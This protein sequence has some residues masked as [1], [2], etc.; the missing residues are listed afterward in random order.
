MKLF[1]NLVIT[2]GVYIWMGLACLSFLSLSGFVLLT[3]Q[4]PLLG[5]ELNIYA[6]VPILAWVLFGLAFLAALVLILKAVFLEREDWW[7]WGTLGVLLL[8]LIMFSLVML[9]VIRSYFFYGRGDGLT[10]LAFLQ[11]TLV[12]GSVAQDDLYPA[13]GFI[14]ASLAN[15]TMI[16]PRLLELNSPGIGPLLGLPF[17]YLLARVALG[18]SRQALLGMLI[19]NAATFGVTSSRFAPQDL[20]NLLSVLFIFLYLRFRWQPDPAGRTLLVLLAVVLTIVHPFS[21]TI[22]ILALVAMEIAGGILNYHHQPYGI[23]SSIQPKISLGLVFILTVV[24]LLWNFYHTYL[25]GVLTQTL[26]YILGKG[27]PSSI[28][29]EYFSM[30]A[31]YKI[32]VWALIPKLYGQ[33]LFNGILALIGIVFFVR[34]LPPKTVSDR[35]SLMLLAYAAVPF[36][37]ALLQTFLTVWRIHPGRA[38]SLVEMVFPVFGAIALLNIFRDKLRPPLNKLRVSMFAVIT[39]ILVIP[40]ISTVLF[41]AHL[42]PFRTW[43]GEQVTRMEYTGLKWFFTNKDDSI[44]IKE[45]GIRH[46]RFVALFPKGIS[47]G[48]YGTRELEVKEHFGYNYFEQMGEGYERNAYI[49]TSEYDWQV[50]MVLFPE[51]G[52][53]NAD[54]LRK[55]DNDPSVSK[56]YTTSR[57][58]EIR[59]VKPL[60]RY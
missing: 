3:Y 9:P 28:T 50:Q 8:Y 16:S 13:R 58:M 25:M 19:L 40:A 54:D 11:D 35:N 37:I 22:L 32:N 23:Y 56:I 42:T 12:R 10:H 15:I 21:A 6:H 7:K 55:T 17:F 57:E 24:F 47:Q 29:E 38:A 33:T 45:L 36:S 60:A 43:P 26:E 27:I 34:R 30:L 51:L 48:W 5:Y 39:I 1:R 53:F 44:D 31:K 4:K 46:F 49:V 18:S 14:Q 20:G 2:Y 52:R 41:V 59:F